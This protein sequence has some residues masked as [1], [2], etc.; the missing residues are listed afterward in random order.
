MKVLHLVPSFALGGMER[1]VCTVINSTTDRY[2]HSILALDQQVDA[3]RW[4]QGKAVSWVQFEKPDKRR[5]FFLTLYRVLK[6]IRPDLLMTYNWGATD[7]IWLGRLAGIPRI[8]HSEHGFNADEGRATNWQ[9]DAMRCLVYRLASKIIVVSAELEG[10][11]RKKY[12]LTPSR[13]ARISNGIDPAYYSPDPDERQRMRE[14]LGFTEHHL[15]IGFSGRLDP[16]KNLGLLS[17]VFAGCLR[18]QPQWRLLIVGDGPERTR[19]EKLCHERSVRSHVVFVGVQADVRS[20]LRAMDVFLLT[21]LREQMPMTLLEAMAVG[22]PIVA[23]KVGEVPHIVENGVHGFVHE[24]GAPTTAFVKSLLSLTSRAARARMGE[25]GR[26]AIV[27]NFQEHHMIE[28]Y[29]SLM[30][31]LVQRAG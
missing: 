1:I 26:Q 25:A 28:Q 31:G 20:Y 15:V 3:R 8:V 7:G 10:L 17:D 5:L 11:L 16:I 13:V 22:L 6:T 19:I 4:I 24:A 14:L 21:S 23:T 30:Q 12:I 27:Q 9:R 29:K 18:E 2:D